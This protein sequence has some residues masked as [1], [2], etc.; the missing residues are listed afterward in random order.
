[1]LVRGGAAAQLLLAALAVAAVLPHAA[2]SSGEV[3]GDPAA[4]LVS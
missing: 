3:S 2:L 1:M 4:V